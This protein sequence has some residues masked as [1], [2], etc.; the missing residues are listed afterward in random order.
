VSE[1]GE[2]GEEM[3]KVTRKRMNA[4]KR[5]KKKEN[6][7]STGGKEEEEKKVNGVKGESS[8][9]SS[10]SSKQKR[11]R[12]G[13]EEESGSQPNKKK[14]KNSTS[15]STSKSSSSSSKSNGEEDEEGDTSS[16][17]DSSRMEEEEEDEEFEEK[18]FEP[19][20][21]LV[22]SMSPNKLM[23]MSSNVISQM[24]RLSEIIHGDDSEREKKRQTTM[25]CNRIEKDVMFR[26][27][28]KDFGDMVASTLHAL[29]YPSS[30][31]DQ[32]RKLMI[33]DARKDESKRKKK[34]SESGT[35]EESEGSSEEENQESSLVCGICSLYLPHQDESQSKGYDKVDRAR[36][37]S[38][39]RGLVVSCSHPNCAR[40]FHTVCVHRTLFRPYQPAVDDSDDEESD[41]EEEE[42]EMQGDFISQ[43]V[44]IKSVSQIQQEEE[45]RLHTHFSS[46]NQFNGW[47]CP[48]HFC[49]CCRNPDLSTP[50]PPHKNDQPI[51][52]VKLVLKCSRCL[53]RICKVF[54]QQQFM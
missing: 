43:P 17:S 32:R 26:G 11:G 16:S 8:S 25:L 46:L 19:R 49:S 53:K 2:L 33:T 9:S 22:G 14:Q 50:I 1:D 54:V 31:D 21:D 39:N 42:G 3:T 30:M 48:S 23:L 40:S 12:D 35:E 37:S 24:V 28:D 34:K 41:E 51:K 36:Q 52:K 38:Y 13:K 6:G 7:S 27:L 20:L 5:K 4:R 29:I 18:K 10:S 47:I 44:E 45:E 15:K